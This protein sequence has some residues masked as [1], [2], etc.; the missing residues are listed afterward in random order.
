MSDVFLDIWKSAR[1]FEGRCQVSTWLLAVAR[2]KALSALRRRTFESLTDD[3]SEA[4]EDLA[5]GPEIAMQKKQKAALLLKCTAKLSPLHREIIDLVYYHE[6]TIDE[7]SVII[8]VP[9]STVKTRMFY[10]RQRLAELFRAQD[11][12]PFSARDCTVFC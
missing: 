12:E 7:V 9:R 2:H 1:R 11:A 10:A 8:G 3:I 6:R 4:I 5:D